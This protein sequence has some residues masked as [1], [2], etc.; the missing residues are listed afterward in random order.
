MN[1][2]SIVVI[3][4]AIVIILSLILVYYTI[5]MGKEMIGRFED[6]VETKYASSSSNANN[7][8]NTNNNNNNNNGPKSES[9]K[10]EN[11]GK[12]ENAQEGINPGKPNAVEGKTDIDKTNDETKK[13]VIE[14][15]KKPA[16]DEVDTQAAEDNKVQQAKDEAPKEESKKQSNLPP[17]SIPL[18]VKSEAVE[19]KSK[20][21]LGTSM[22]MEDYFT[23]GKI[24]LTKL[25]PSEIKFLF[26]STKDD[27][28][29]NS[30]VEELKRV[31]SIIFSKLSSDDIATIKAIG[32]KYGK[33]MKIL[34]PNIDVAEVKAQKEAAK[35]IQN[36]S[37]N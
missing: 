27:L 7:T 8:N 13:A 14:G 36:Q 1:G 6:K 32:N 22:S 21:V 4:T 18:P 20:S 26:S 2:K 3:I 23:I 25:G 11:P 15:E 30:S 28:F 12:K 35:R 16:T 17:V 34:D 19:D 29:I 37:Q 33:E 9:D 31:R 5:N 10:P 24:T